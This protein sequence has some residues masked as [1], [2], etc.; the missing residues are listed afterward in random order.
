MDNQFP[1][2]EKKCYL[3]GPT[4][5]T[6]P[7]GDSMPSETIVLGN[8]STTNYEN[9]AKIIDDK[10]GLTHTFNFIIPRGPKGDDGTSVTILGSYNSVEELRENHPIG[11]IGDS[12]LVND[13]LYV[14]DDN[15]ND[16]NDVGV[17]KGPKGDTGDQGPT[18]P[19]GD[20]GIQGP[21]GDIGPKGDTGNQGPIGPK[22]DQGIQGPI[23]PA[24]PLAIPTSIFIRFN[25]TSTDEEVA[26][27]SRIPFDVKIGDD[28]N[29]FKLDLEENT[30]TFLQTG[31]YYIDFIVQAHP[32]N[33]TPLKDDHDMVAIGF[34]KVDEETVYAGGSMWDSDNSTVYII[35]KGIVTLPYE[36]EIFELVNLGK[37]P[38]YLNSPNS[39]YIY[40]ESSF[41]NPVVNLSIQKIK[42]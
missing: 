5:P 8:V 36:N 23:G 41:V 31:T 9:E 14:W 4:G 22:G 39:A 37:Y 11:K 3:V 29:L 13:N 7:K 15:K 6:G 30:I 34:K 1:I 38:I 25:T 19:K 32:I 40:S 18:G 16:W 42:E 24:G 17:I 20:Q 28:S 27:K 26:S 10:Q 21:K 35:G 12:Y 33:Q 2:L